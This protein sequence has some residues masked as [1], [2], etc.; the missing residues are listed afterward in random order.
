MGKKI[1]V[2]YKYGDNNVYPLPRATY[3]LT[4]LSC[5]QQTTVRHYVDELYV[6]LDINDH[7]LKG[8][9]DGESLAHFK[10]S[11]IES[12]LRAKIHDSSITIVMIS[13]NMKDPYKPESDQWIPWEIAYSLREYTRGYRTSLSNAVLA[14]V[15]PDR[16]NSYGYYLRD[17]TCCALKCRTQ[18]VD[19]VFQIIRDNMFN[20]KQRTQQGCNQN[21]NVYTGEFSYI[22]AV[23]W[24]EFISDVSG[25]L[26]RVIRINENI[27]AYDIVKIVK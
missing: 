23:K 10:D 15:L 3:G 5:Y 6:H 19:H 26:D 2:S 1:F 14:V 22:P 18:M 21:I 27:T 8:E 11:T 20:A 24:N 13:P 25:N 17:N 7:I 12:K 16:N 4:L 9:Q